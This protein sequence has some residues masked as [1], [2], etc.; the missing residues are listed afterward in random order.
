MPIKEKNL[1]RI[2]HRVSTAAP[3]SSMST[4]LRL[5]CLLDLLLS[6][7]HSSLSLRATCI[8][9]RLRPLAKETRIN[10]LSGR[11]AALRGARNIKIFQYMPRF[12]RSARLALHPARTINQGFPKGP[13]KISGQRKSFCLEQTDGFSLVE[14][15]IAFFI[16]TLGLLSAAQLLTITIKLDALARSKNTAALAA[17]N[18]IDHLSDLYRR[19]PAAAEFTIGAHH[20][21]EL[22][23]IRNPLN[24]KVQNRYKITWFVG[25]ITDPRPGMDLPGRIISVQ[26]TPMLTE[27]VENTSSF[28]NKKTTLSAVIAAEP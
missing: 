17:Q 14:L 23:E 2:F 10:C 19:N 11:I 5:L 22:V 9:A 16:L 7:M 26:A 18:K 13:Y 21:E 25:D 28:Q 1:T 24:Q 4:A 6:Y 27:N 15:M 20:A 8:H 12:L 3:Q